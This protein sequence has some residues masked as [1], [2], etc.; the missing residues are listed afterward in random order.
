MWWVRGRM[1]HARRSDA[2]RH[3]A[4]GW[5]APSIALALVVV[6]LALASC[7]SAST[8]SAA[9]VLKNAQ[10]HFDQTK[11]FHFTMSASHLGPNDPLAVESASGDVQRPDQLSTT[12]TVHTAGFTL[13]EQLIIIGSQQWITNPI[14]GGWQATDQFGGFLTIFD[15]DKGVGAVLT[16]M[17][18]PSTPQSTK[19][20]NTPCWQISGKAATSDVAAMVGVDGGDVNAGT[21]VDATVCIGQQDN[22]L[23]SVTV[24]G[25]ISTTDTARTTRTFMLSNF[26]KP[27]T[28]Q[29]PTA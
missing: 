15:P 24:T 10:T 27:V 25:A 8:P 16:H 5:L 21:T 14:T 19:A 2:A 18:Q 29:P 20:G 7:G 1:G 4:R 6:A 22:E 12:A 17:Q 26:D 11:S 28:I 9:T 13:K 3:H 23:Y